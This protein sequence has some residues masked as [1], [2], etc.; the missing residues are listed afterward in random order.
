MKIV[1]NIG[2]IFK[3]ADY[4]MRKRKGE[5]MP[6]SF[7]IYQVTKRCNGRCPFCSIWRAEPGE[8]LTLGDLEDLFSKP[9]MHGLRWINLTGG[10]PFLRKDLSETV[11]IMRRLL[12]NLEM[13]ALPSNGFAPKIT[14]EG[15]KKLLDA[16][17]GK[18]PDGEEREL[19]LSV[20]ISF[21]ALGE[22][23]DRSRGMKDGF[24]K[25]LES[26]KGLLK[27]AEDNPRL[28]VGIEVVITKENVEKLM[29]IFDY[30]WPMT[31][32]I[33][34]TPVI[35]TP[36]DFFGK[37]DKDLGLS[38]DDIERME[39]FFS[40]MSTRLPAYAYYFSKVLDIKKDERGGKRTYPCLG[41][42]STM[43]MDSNG[44]I[45]PCL[46]APSHLR[47][48]N[49]KERDIEEMWMGKDGDAMRANL[50]KFK[51]CEVCTNNCDIVANLKDETINFLG[52][53]LAHP[54]VFAALVKDVR[55]GKFE[56]YV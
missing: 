20:N 40:E 54:M 31:N 8:E 19:P 14:V 17:R 21:D 39:N 43:F 38:E 25:A 10:E 47:L 48:G 56:K 11:E 37:P 52:Y 7:L 30:F 35:V 49:V 45:Y 26:L 2:G 24:K 42:Y 51:F 55:A 33:N 41:G 18:G 53:L 23:H 46:I 27:I 36:S 22:A 50:K 15:T 9:F 12:P 5:G 29:E 13:V 32:H 3:G 1:K 16:L 6:P 4:R 44:W 34:F 28:E